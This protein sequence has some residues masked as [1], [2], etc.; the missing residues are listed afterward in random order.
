M[1]IVIW[2]DT[3]IYFRQVLECLSWLLFWPNFFSQLDLEHSYRSVVLWLALK[4]LL[5][6]NLLVNVCEHKL[7]CIW[8]FWWSASSSLFLKM[9]LHSL[10]LNFPLLCWFLMCRS[11]VSFLVNFSSHCVHLY[12]ATL[13]DSI[14]CRSRFSCLLNFSLQSEHSY[15]LHSWISLMW[16]CIVSSLENTLSHSGDLVFLFL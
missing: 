5:R 8:V 15:F 13:W 12:S 9:T 10:H 1:Y 6:L 7:H 16:R 11:R 4:C 2:N 14:L 3:S